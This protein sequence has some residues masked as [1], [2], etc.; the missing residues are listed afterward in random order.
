L[1][2]ADAQAGG[3]CVAVDYVPNTEAKTDTATNSNSNS[4]SY[5]NTANFNPNPNPDASITVGSTQGPDTVGMC[6][7][8]DAN[9]T[10]V[11]APNQA[12]CSVLLRSVSCSGCF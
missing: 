9:R 3:E 10:S 11:L 12:Q 2:T 6:C 7:L 5:S 8:L 1:C 4:Y